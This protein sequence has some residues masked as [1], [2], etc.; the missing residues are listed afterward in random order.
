MP[1]SCPVASGR[2]SRTLTGCARTGDPPPGGATDPDT[3]GVR[4]RASRDG[5]GWDQLEGPADLDYWY[6]DGSAEFADLWERTEDGP[7]FS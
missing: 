4:R 6:D 5:L 7:V 3:R 2:R 1:C